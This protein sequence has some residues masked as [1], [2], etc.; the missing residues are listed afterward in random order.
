MNSS[1]PLYLLDT[2]LPNLTTHL[3]LPL[4]DPLPHRQHPPIPLLKLPRNLLPRPI[5]PRK[6]LQRH[7]FHLIA[8]P[9]KIHHTVP[10]R[11]GLRA[12][13]RHNPVLRTQQSAVGEPD[14]GVAEIDDR[15]LGERF[16]VLPLAAVLD[17]EAAEPVED[18]GDAAEIGVGG[19]AEGV[20]AVVWEF[21]G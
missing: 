8:R 13:S 9:D 11:V 20:F 6:L 1:H 21:P 15:V 2:H 10:I 3:L 16:D 17:L 12:R 18:E 7:H 14:H 19:E 5:L 4:L